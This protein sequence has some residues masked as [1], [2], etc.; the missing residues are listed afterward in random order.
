M[1]I[2]LTIGLKPHYKLT[3]RIFSLV[4][5]KALNLLK[6]IEVT[7]QHTILNLILKNLQPTNIKII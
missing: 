3:V 4:I 2:S 7:Y 5:E 6:N 1:V